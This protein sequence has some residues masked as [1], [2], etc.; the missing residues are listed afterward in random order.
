MN[1]FI[2]ILILFQFGLCFTFA[3]VMGNYESNFKTLFDKKDKANPY[4]FGHNPAYLKNEVSNEILYLIS[5]VN[6]ESGDFRKFTEPGDV[7]YYSLSATGKKQIDSSQIFRGSFGFQRTENNKWQWLFTREYSSGSPFLIGDSTT[8]N[9]RL[10]GIFMSAE[11]AASILDKLDLGFSLNYNVDDGLKLAHP[12]PT[13][14]NREIK[15]SSG[16]AYH[17]DNKISLGLRATVYDNVEHIIYSQ[18]PG[19]L[20]TEIILL[21]FRG[22]DYPNVFRMSSESRYSYN[23]GYSAGLNFLFEESSFFKLSAFADAGFNKINVKDGG[24]SPISEGFWKNNTYNSGLVSLFKLNNSIYLSLLYTFKSGD[25]WAKYPA[26]NNFYSNNNWDEH[27][28]ISGLEYSFDNELTAGLEGGIKYNSYNFKDYY[29]NIFSKSKMLNY[30]ISIGIKANWNNKFSSFISAGFNS[31][32]IGTNDLTYSTES[33]YFTDYRIKDVYFY[34][35]GFNQYIFNLITAYS[36][37]FGGEILLNLNYSNS[38]PNNS[39]KFK[40]LHRS[41]SAIVLEYRVAAY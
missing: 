16:F 32:N 39:S 5:N 29:S 41:N 28:I 2:K 40:D 22:Y 12:R 23:N 35:T 6:D 3:Q 33:S 20:T 38:I 19:A 36:P 13:S 8:G 10:N 18:D 31:N 14:K 34:Q 25:N 24:S 21:K 30:M 37:G 17:I 26:F 7:R 15:F 27:C 1:T 11:Y 4:Y 9:T